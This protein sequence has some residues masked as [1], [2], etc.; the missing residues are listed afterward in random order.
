MSSEV[1]EDYGFDATGI[2]TSPRANLL[3]PGDYLFICQK[4]TINN[5][6]D[7]NGR[8]IDCE[9]LVVEGI[10]KGRK[11]WNKFNVENQNEQAVQIGKR[12]LA[13][14]MASIG[15]QAFR[16][17]SELTDK[18]FCGTV[19]FAKGASEGTEINVIKKFKKQSEYVAAGPKDDFNPFAS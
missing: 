2:D 17:L 4:A 7:N 19:G 9:F 10:G 12:E 13:L 16:S 15:L 14:F 1:S 8:Y 5:T 18:P 3:Q 11:V 6:K